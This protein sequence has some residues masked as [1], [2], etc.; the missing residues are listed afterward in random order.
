MRLRSALVTLVMLTPAE[1]RPSAP[2]SIPASEPT[3]GPRTQRESEPDPKLAAE[4]A[5]PT[6]REPDAFLR[7]L[8]HDLGVR[9]LSECELATKE[10][11]E[12]R[13]KTEDQ[14][15]DAEAM[16]RKLYANEHSRFRATIM[17]CAGT[18]AGY[19][20]PPFTLDGNL[21]RHDVDK[22][23]SGAI[24]GLTIWI[25]PTATDRADIDVF[26]GDGRSQPS[27]QWVAAEFDGG[28]WTFQQ[29]LVTFWEGDPLASGR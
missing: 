17:G 11:L 3:S 7:T 13:S 28:A 4:P 1:C 27:E 8:F 29:R 22:T 14:A 18:L 5:S 16:A 25:T 24:A 15:P 12:R 2:A 21:D 19:P 9:S 26:L 6:L 10:S 23:K 20:E